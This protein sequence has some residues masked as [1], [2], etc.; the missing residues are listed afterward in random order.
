MKELKNNA[1]APIYK[2]RSYLGCLDQG[3]KVAT[4]HVIDLLRYLSPSL[5]SCV[6]FGILLVLET[7]F[8]PLP[9]SSYRFDASPAML[10]AGACVLLAL[11]VES[12]GSFMSQLFDVLSKYSEQG[13]WPICKF[14]DAMKS[15]KKFFMKSCVFLLVGV[16][17]VALFVLPTVLL[18]G[19]HSIYT[20]LILLVYLLLLFIPYM[21]IGWDYLLSHH[22]TLWHSFKRIKVIYQNIGSLY[23]VWFV[24]GL[25][26]LL[27][28]IVAW[29]PTILLVYAH[30]ASM[31]SVSMG[32][33]TD[34]PV[35]VPVL[36]ILFTIISTLLSK[37]GTCLLF[38]P[39]SYLYG[40]IVTKQKEK[41]KF[42]EEE[43]KYSSL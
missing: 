36:V 32:D 24:A 41:M 19:W 39:L 8:Y 34:L 37:M 4:R 11:F 40:S 28:C 31:F 33:T 38:F 3:L 43:K 22:H 12:E 29:L 21:M 7:Y 23:A 16:L 1:D 30:R 42:D 2:V 6:F 27:I 35:I 25:L 5:L 20:Y 10:I 14:K 15:S 9:Y 26:L 17:L 18:L 13:A